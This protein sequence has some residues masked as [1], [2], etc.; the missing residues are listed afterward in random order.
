MDRKTKVFDI[1]PQKMGGVDARDNATLKPGA[2]DSIPATTNDMSPFSGDVSI[3]KMGGFGGESI[4]Q[5]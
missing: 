5:K 2:K 1:D 3:K 4:T